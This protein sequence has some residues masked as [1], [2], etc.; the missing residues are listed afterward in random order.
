[1]RIELLNCV[2]ANFREKIQSGTPTPVQPEYNLAPLFPDKREWVYVNSGSFHLT[3]GRSIACMIYGQRSDGQWPLVVVR[4][5]PTDNFLD[6]EEKLTAGFA[7]LMERRNC[8]CG[9]VGYKTTGKFD[10]D[11]EA[12]KNPIYSACALH[13]VPDD[14]FRVSL[15]E[16]T[17]AQYREELA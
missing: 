4:V 12:V 14:G 7:G 3:P 17:A 2:A 1:M 15:D 8:A 16:A 10:E 6:V 5:L 9:V 13:P 11:G